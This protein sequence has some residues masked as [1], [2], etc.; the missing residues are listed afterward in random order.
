M[1]SLFIVFASVLTN[2]SFTNKKKS[3]YYTKIYWKFV[4]FLYR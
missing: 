4:I 3:N 2:V 1:G